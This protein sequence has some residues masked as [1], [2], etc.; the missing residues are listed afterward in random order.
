MAWRFVKQPNGMLARFSDVVEDFTHYNM[1]PEEA[2]Q[3]CVD[4]LNVGKQTAEEKVQAGVDDIVPWTK[5][6][7]GDGLARWREAIEMMGLNHKPKTVTRR[8]AELTTPA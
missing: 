2:I 7:K 4:E 6:T 1:T 8:V 5:N 3:L